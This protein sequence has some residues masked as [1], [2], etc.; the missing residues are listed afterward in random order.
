M[1]AFISLSLHWGDREVME[2][3]IRVAIKWVVVCVQGV[4]K[5]NLGK[6]GYFFKEKCQSGLRD[7]IFCTV[8]ALTQHARYAKTQSNT[9]FC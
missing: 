9:T 2:V 5:G 1:A 3:A 8:V 4:L 7:P 6:W